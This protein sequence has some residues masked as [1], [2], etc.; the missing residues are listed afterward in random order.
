MVN[1]DIG[2]T[3]EYSPHITEVLRNEMHIQMHKR[4]KRKQIV[5]GAGTL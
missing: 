5:D 2:V 3:L 4:A 1:R